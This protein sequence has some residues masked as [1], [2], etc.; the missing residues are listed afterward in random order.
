MEE[1]KKVGL[2]GLTMLVI[3]SLVG[4][5]IFNLMK[6]MSDAAALVPMLIA[7]GITACGMGLF[8]LCFQNL[9]D[10]RPDLTAGIFSYAKEG[11]G[12]FMGFSSAW[13]YWLS[14]CLGNVA[15][16]GLLFSS[17]SYFFDIFGDGNNIWSII[18]A[19]TVIWS[20]HFLILRGVSTAA[21]INTLVTIA[22]LVPLVVFI[23]AAMTVFRLDTVSI[24]VFGTASHTF[25]LGAVFEQVNATM[26]TALWVFIGIEGAVVFSS[27]AQNKKDIGTASVLA[28]VAMVVI[29]V[30]ISVV[31][32]GVMPRSE[33]ITLK[34]PAM[35]FV[36]ERIIGPFG[37]IFVNAGVV[38]AVVGAILAWTLFAAELPYQAAK[39]G[40]FPK[41]FA[42]ENENH[43]PVNALLVTN[44]CVQVFLITFLF[45]K[46]AYNFGF[47]LASSAILLPYA[48]TAFYQLKHSMALPKHTPRRTFN[49]VVGILASVYS[50]Y[51]IYAGGWDYF[52]LTM[53]A[54]ALGM[55]VYIKMRKET[56]QPLFVGVE[57]IYALIIVCL[58]VLGVLLMFTGG[59]DLSAILE[60]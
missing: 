11:F 29:Y 30:L 7:W 28:L 40:A 18:G 33:I 6:D 48:F 44:C 19:S 25:E 39:E 60:G 42:K 36:L 55:I 26:M 2:L 14:A 24:D 16:A 17:L 46:S 41:F 10:K 20:V 13:G 56:K 21:F 43:A 45:T 23:I 37:A 34:T 12:S 9:S 51:L 31:S 5:G 58:A 49:I 27:R 53:I 3:G 15:Y 50:F 47:A 22:K 32:L 59:I 57:K 38:L 52:L 54:Y 8:V 4:G 1:E 35:A